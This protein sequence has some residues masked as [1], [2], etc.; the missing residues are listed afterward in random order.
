MGRLLSASSL[1][2]KHNI[3]NEHILKVNVSVCIYRKD[4][5]IESNV[6]GLP[7]GSKRSWKFHF[8]LHVCCFFF[9]FYNEF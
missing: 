3:L 8:L 6:E 4:M 2:Y 5:G 9:F 7:S 1:E